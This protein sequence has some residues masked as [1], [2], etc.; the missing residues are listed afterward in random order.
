M[1]LL[2]DLETQWAEEDGVEADLDAIVIDDDDELE[3]PDAAL[4]Q[5]HREPD[6][7]QP[8]VWRRAP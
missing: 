8:V 4:E 3:Q 1:G 7:D 5:L 6:D 2:S